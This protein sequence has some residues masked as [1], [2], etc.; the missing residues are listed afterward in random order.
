[1]YHISAVDVQQLMGQLKRQLRK[2]K[3]HTHHE[4]LGPQAVNLQHDQ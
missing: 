2:C 4:F 1:M 3:K